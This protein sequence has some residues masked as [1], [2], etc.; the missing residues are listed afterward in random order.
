MQW[1]SQ[2]MQFSNEAK[3]DFA[4]E[5]NADAWVCEYALVKDCIVVRHEQY[6]SGIRRTI[7]IPHVC[8]KFNVH[9]VDTFEMLRQL[10]V[11]FR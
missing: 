5:D 1:A 10:G 9:F 6:D 7:P 2:Q 3:A 8:R 11:T 4:R